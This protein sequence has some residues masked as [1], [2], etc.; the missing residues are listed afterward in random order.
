MKRFNFD[1]DN[2]NDAREYIRNRTIQLLRFG[3][4]LESVHEHVFGLVA[5]YRYKQKEH[6][7]IYLYKS[8]RN[9]GKYKNIVQSY[10]LP[11]LTSNQC[12]LEE[13]L[14][15]KG[16]EHVCI[17][18][19]DC[20]EYNLIESFYGDKITKRSK[21]FLMNHIDE[22]LAILNMFIVSE[23]AKKAYMLHPII[24]SDGD[25]CNYRH[26]LK[27]INYEIIILAMEYRNVANDYLSYRKINDPL[28][29]VKLSMLCE[30]NDMLVADKI[31]NYKDFCL[32][33]NGIHQRSTE[34]NEYF[35]NWFKRLNLSTDLV[36][37]TIRNINI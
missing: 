15:N 26:L 6:V 25:L 16:Y 31:Q 36:N 35:F 10:G 8:H 27:D 33:H 1:A 12:N 7:A 23:T 17:N 28:T 18:V 11:I 19:N 29:D 2:K 5:L 21:Q 32:Y 14:I 24:Q 34:L 30:V 37:N 9:Q 13:F 4:K 20:A 22:G 3:V